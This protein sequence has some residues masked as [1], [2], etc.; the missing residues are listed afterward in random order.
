MSRF[1]ICS[2]GKAQLFILILAPVISMNKRTILW[3]VVLLV[4]A[5]GWYY[6][7]HYTNMLS[8]EYHYYG[9]FDDVRG[10]QESSPV[11][12]LGVKVGRVDKVDLHLK[13]QVKVDFAISQNVRLA[14][15]TKAVISTGDVN[16]S[17]SVRL[18]PGG[19]SGFITPGGTLA[20]D[21]DS[22]MSENF[23]AKITPMLHNGKVLLKSADSGLNDFNALVL[24]GWG[25][26]T[27]SE[28]ARFNKV[29]GN[30]ARTSGK[31]NQ[32][33]QNLQGTITNLD[34]ATAHPTSKI[35]D[36]N[37]TLVNAEK[38]TAEASK[39]SLFADVEDLERS[40]NKFSASVSKLRRNKL[41]S[42]TLPYQ[43]AS[44]SLDTL[45]RSVKD[46]MKDP[47]SPVRI[48][49]GKKK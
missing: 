11:Y 31:A 42:D 30:F 26:R 39:K 41:V 27:Q 48:L 19:H 13:Q 28:L 49:S 43:N 10:L 18:E 21:F 22:S 15:G 2:P 33:V 47:P 17:K 12:Y 1:F 32:R 23:H 7:K 8:R 5:A 40:I 36:M 29:L 35:N 6:V 14:A 38:K 45:N 37:K 16:G 20:T 24:G 44:R 3:V 4:V 9:Y 34:S 46:Y 25:H